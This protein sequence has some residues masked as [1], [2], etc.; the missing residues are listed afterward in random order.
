MGEWNGPKG[1]F[2]DDAEKR[3]R[4][5]AVA[6]NTD[7]IDIN[8]E[9]DTCWGGEDDLIIRRGKP[10]IAIQDIIATAIDT[11]NENPKML[12]Y[13][14]NGETL[15]GI[16]VHTHVDLFKQSSISPRV[17][18]TKACKV[19][20]AIQIFID[21][22]YAPDATDALGKKPWVSLTS[23]LQELCRQGATGGSSKSKHRPRRHSRNKR[24]VKVN[25]H[26]RRRH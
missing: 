5:L 24:K 26:K 16:E 23:K 17:I 19:Q 21:K 9:L 7:Y 3:T 14:F 20:A 13:K 25:T 12:K 4:A 8:T 18:C 10:M 6:M 2:F 22:V 11:L 1:G 15:E